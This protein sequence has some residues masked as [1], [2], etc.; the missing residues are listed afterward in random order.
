MSYLTLASNIMWLSGIAI[1]IGILVDAAVVMVENASHQLK[2]RFGD[3]KVHGDT[4][5]IVIKAC[6]L[7]GRPIFFSVLIML[8]SFLPVFTFGGQEGKLSHPLAFT[9]S[10]AMVGVALLAVT[11]VPAL[12]PLLVRGRLRCEEEN[13][14]VRGFIHIYRPVLS[15]AIERPGFVWWMMAV[16]LSLAA[17]FI[18]SPWVSP[19]ALALGM[20]FVVL[21][22][23]RGG[24]TI[25]LVV[26]LLVVG[27]FAIVA[28]PS[29]A[30][31]S[32]AFARQAPRFVI[33]VI[34]GLLLVA[35]L[36]RHWRT[37]AVVSRLAVASV[38]DS[39]FR[40]LGSEFMPDLD[41]GSVMD[42]PL[43]APRIAM[44]EAVD[45][46]MVRDRLL[47][48]FP[49]VEQAVGKVGR[50]ETA[51]DPSPVDMVETI[52]SMKPRE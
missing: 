21:G 51:T 39:R 14:I 48:S 30:H 22:V 2:E 46:V 31:I 47:R 37:A 5:E 12:I 1:S 23:R 19:V 20:T 27:F 6:R 33:A 49:E 15:W 8:I 32:P 16:I 25:W 42:M 43:T 36:L 40:K 11:L 41:E 52:V 3:G 4:T 7:V 44:G 38:A 24:W 35:A 29:N 13:W 34:L 9:K 50:A 28:P 18:A 26:G 17:G 10:F 45:D